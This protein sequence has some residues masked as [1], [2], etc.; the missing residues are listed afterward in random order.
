MITNFVVILTFLSASQT[1]ESADAFEGS[2]NVTCN[3]TSEFDCQTGIC[4]PV[5]WHCDGTPDCSN[6]LDEAGC[7]I[8]RCREGQV[9][10]PTSKK[11]IPSTWRCD[12]DVD[13]SFENHFDQWDEDPAHCGPK[14]TCPWNTI[15]CNATQ[16]CLHVSKFCDSVDD[17]GGEDE[18]S[19]C[20]DSGCNKK[21]CEFKC[22]MTKEGPH[23][24]CK[25]GY[26]L[27]TDNSTCVDANECE[28]DGSCDQICAN[29]FGSFRCSCVPGYKEVNHTK[30]E[31]V[32]VPPNEPATIILSS[33]SDI[34]RIALNGSDWSGDSIQRSQTLAL[35]FDHRNHRFCY[36]HQNRGNNTDAAMYC[37]DVDEL[38]NITK[39]PQPSLLSF[40]SVTHIA[41][42]WVSGNWYF[43]DDSRELIFLCT[44]NLKYCLII[45]DINLNKPHGI[46][47]DPTK[48]FMF[49]TKWGTVRPMLERAQ[50][51]GTD[52]I[53]VDYAVQHVYWVDTYLDFIERIDYDGKNRKTVRKGYPVQNLFDITVFENNLY[54]TS[55]KN[56]SV[57]RINKYLTDDFETLTNNSKPF[58]IHV[59]HRQRQPDVAH[60][61][62]N[63]N[64]GCAHI[65][66]PAWN[67]NIAT[68]R[69][70]CHNGYKL[71]KNGK[72]TLNHHS[73]FLL[74]GR[75]R[76]G[77]IKGI[78]MI[79]SPTQG[80]QEEAIVP[81]T[82]LHRPST[83]DFDVRTRYIY[84]AD[85]NPPKIGRQK[86]DGLDR[87]IWKGDDVSNCE[88]L[89]VDWVGRNLY[90]TDDMAGTLSV[91]PLDKPLLRKNLHINITHARAVT[92]HLDT[93]EP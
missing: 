5:L 87:E 61:C 13:C 50:L 92:L 15:L 19:F 35:E 22:K 27:K 42:D 16:K 55:W 74:M 83:L 39:Y 8:S 69:C 86:F 34:R 11:C 29:T 47:L 36:L 91:A 53:T 21:K 17:C 82:N 44:G 40:E 67:N 2:P 81:I 31:A 37:A 18:G 51:D 77:M 32:N 43:L 52:R 41:L 63:K 70:Y 88:G 14:S 56:Q 4:I 33:S 66:I 3:K 73:S 68:A 24:Y 26:K 64:G 59:Y 23:C 72:C 10:C 6:G 20:T 90:W 71:L 54:V 78:P 45:I 49:F 28:V 58:S 30:C 57:I 93:N 38:S 25:D 85:Q 79:P 84:W 62:K 46:A 65:C 89:A 1:V 80:P 76:P 60:P 7:K 12:G 48:G 9:M 75:G